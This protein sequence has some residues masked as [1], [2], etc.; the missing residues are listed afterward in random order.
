VV[1]KIIAY[2]RRLLRIGPRREGLDVSYSANYDMG[3]TVVQRPPYRYMWYY[4]TAVRNVLDMP[5]RVVWFEAYSWVGGRWVANNIMRRPLTGKDFSDWY[6]DAEPIIEGVIPAGCVALNDCK[7]H[8]SNSAPIPGPVKWAYK[9]VDP[10]G[11]E[12]YAEVIIER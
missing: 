9:A 5:L 12:Y 11:A 7:W 10:S 8:G 3:A 1:Q 6:S 2:L 4:T